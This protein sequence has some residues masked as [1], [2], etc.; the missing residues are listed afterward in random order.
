MFFLEEEGGRMIDPSLKIVSRYIMD[1]NNYSKVVGKSTRVE[2]WKGERNMVVW[3]ICVCIWEED[4]DL[5]IRW[6]RNEV[7]RGLFNMES[8]DKRLLS[9]SDVSLGDREGKLYNLARRATPERQ[10]ARRDLSRG[11]R[12]PWGWWWCATMI[13]PPPRFFL[14]WNFFVRET[15]NDTSSSLWIKFYIEKSIYR[16]IIDWDNIATVV[17]VIRY[18]SS[19]VR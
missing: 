7:Q 9:P 12:F 10:I 17:V 14:S 5:P 16:R 13:E 6:S 1:N 18:I 11:I 19:F 15:K 2:G 3:E 4:L 8:S